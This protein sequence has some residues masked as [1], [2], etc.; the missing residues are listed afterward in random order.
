MN[1]RR[2]AM[3]LCMLCALV[4][5]AV[6]AQ[7][8][9][10]AG[11]TAFTCKA[12]EGGVGFSDAHCLTAVGSGA[13]FKHIEI[14]VGATTEAVLTNEKTNASTTAAVS[15][16]MVSKKSG[17]TIE[18]ECAVL[19][20]TGSGQNVAGPPM[21]AE[22]TIS[23]EFKTCKVLK[24]AN[25]TVAEPI[26]VIEA[27]VWSFHTGAGEKEQGEKTSPKVT[28]FTEIVFSGASCPLPGTFPVEGTA[29]S[30]SKGTTSYFNVGEDELTFA[31][32]PAD[33]Q[34][35]ATRSGRA[36]GDASFTPLSA[37]TTAT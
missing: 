23:L 28:I 18:V 2:I 34:G 11:T 8:A 35:V 17:V 31:K 32:E 29:V 30:R 12:V 1:G 24:P 16:K 3:S 10:A 15:A 36:K 26:K 27:K 14:A 13:K 21:K 20:G 7:S 19:T 33:L 9:A 5:S 6:A 37:T 4:V 22:G 25:C